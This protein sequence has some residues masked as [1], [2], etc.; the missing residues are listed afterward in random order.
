[1]NITIRPP[2]VED[3]SAINAMRRMDGVREN[4]LGMISETLERSVNFIENLSRNDHMLVAEV[5]GLVVGFASL[6]HHVRPRL[7]HSASI[8]I[9]IHVDYQRRGIGRK[10][11]EALLDIADNWLML[12][13][14]E[15][16][17]LKG[18]DG[19]KKLYESLGFKEEGIKK[20]A[21]IRSGAYVD[22]IM[23]G[24]IHIPMQLRK[25]VE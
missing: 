12:T 14:V 21:V 6:M 22:E 18:N 9:S 7:N 24:R 16:G 15:L 19:A 1:M 4:T 5:D 13:R 2:V 17:V 8:G 20:M 23:M 25:T 3:A 10:L 11:M